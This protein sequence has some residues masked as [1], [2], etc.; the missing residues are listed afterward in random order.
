MNIDF[1]RKFVESNSQDLT[2][3]FDQLVEKP[4]GELVGTNARNKISLANKQRSALNTNRLK[5]INNLR[6]LLLST[7]IDGN[8][9]T[10]NPDILL[11]SCTHTLDQFDQ[12]FSLHL[13]KMEIWFNQAFDDSFSDKISRNSVNLIRFVNKTI[14]DFCKANQIRSE[15]DADEFCCRFYLCYSFLKDDELNMVFSISETAR[16]KW[17][18]FTQ[19]MIDSIKISNLKQEINSLQSLFDKN[20]KQTKISLLLVDDEQSNLD[21]YSQIVDTSKFILSSANSAEEAIEKLEK[22]SYQMIVSDLRMADKTGMDILKYI[23]KHKLDTKFILQTGHGTIDLAIQAMKQGAFDFITKPVD[24]NQLKHIIESCRRQIINDLEEKHNKEKQAQENQFGELLKKMTGSASSDQAKQNKVNKKD[25]IYE[26]FI[27]Q[28]KKELLMKD[29][30]NL[31]Q[32]DIFERV[33][34]NT[35]FQKSYRQ[36]QRWVKI[37]KGLPISDLLLKDN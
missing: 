6:V 18:I 26:L 3:K 2:A 35:G 21:M 37:N 4:L 33:K 36:F 28:F 7:L 34:Q 1:L 16:E 5:L 14:K 31:N 23:N 19:L 17:L 10:E 32:E 25:D 30:L 11:Q 8:K 27:E 12:I 22:E 9:A 29:E 20:L 15:S 24:L 13:E